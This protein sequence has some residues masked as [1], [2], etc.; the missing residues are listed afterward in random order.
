MWSGGFRSHGS[1][2]GR[3]GR[4]R[5]WRNRRAGHT[6][7]PEAR[8][9]FGEFQFDVVAGGATGLGFD[10]LRDNFLLGFLVG[11]KNQLTGSQ[12]RGNANDSAMSEDE[13]GLGGFGERFAL[14]RTFDGAGTI[15]GD[16]NLEGH[17][18]GTSGNLG[19]RLG[20]R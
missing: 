11:E 14:V 5:S 17:G 15:D 1:R 4:S 9:G 19:G 7:A 12:W 6:E 10:D 3:R 20:S 18:L 8:S 13:N 16:G 2:L